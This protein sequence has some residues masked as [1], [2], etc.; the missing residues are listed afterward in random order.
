MASEAAS[1]AR[2][3]PLTPTSGTASSRQRIPQPSSGTSA[4][5]AVR[6]YLEPVTALDGESSDTL[7]SLLQ[8]TNDL[9]RRTAQ[10]H[11]I[12]RGSPGAGALGSTLAYLSPKVDEIA[13][14]LSEVFTK[15]ENFPGMYLVSTQFPVFREVLNGPFNDGG[16]DP[17]YRERVHLLLEKLMYVAGTLRGH[18]EMVL[19]QHS[20]WKAKLAGEKPPRLARKL[21]FN[22]AAD[23][24]QSDQPGGEMATVSQAQQEF[25]PTEH[26]CKG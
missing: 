10:T 12:Q 16:N 14:K 11:R 9:R 1:G 5:T 4:T 7:K 21:N 24:A 17:G 26:N 8:A 6:S 23:P 2:R 18:L 20:Y 15:Y 22:M 3:H 25:L 19:E 13:D